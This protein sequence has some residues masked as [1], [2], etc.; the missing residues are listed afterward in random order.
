MAEKTPIEKA[1]IDGTQEEG[2]LS[3]EQLVDA[4]GGLSCAPST[5]EPVDPDDDARVGRKIV[6]D[7]CCVGDSRLPGDDEAGVWR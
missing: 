2:E 6:P 1:E 5:R 3:E 7:D 4:A